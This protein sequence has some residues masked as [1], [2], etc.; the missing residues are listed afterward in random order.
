[1]M[2]LERKFEIENENGSQVTELRLR[3]KTNCMLNH[4]SAYMFSGPQ[5]IQYSIDAMTD[6]TV[7]RDNGDGSMLANVNV[8]LRA[9]LYG[10]DTI[11][12]LVYLEKEGKRSRTYGTQIWKIIHNRREDDVFDVL[13]EPIL[14]MDG[15]LTCVVKKQRVD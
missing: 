3:Y 6:L 14:I 5:I 11:E 13:E 7:R 9:P 2:E 1:M 12:V 4:Y 8:N 10:G 15:S